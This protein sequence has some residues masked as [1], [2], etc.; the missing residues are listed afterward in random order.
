MPNLS[1]SSKHPIDAMRR[2][3]LPSLDEIANGGSVCKSTNDNVDVIR[4]YAP[5]MKCIFLAV[6]MTDGLFQSLVN[7]GMT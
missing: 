4:H 6:R 1:G 2:N 7:F 3:T 5:L